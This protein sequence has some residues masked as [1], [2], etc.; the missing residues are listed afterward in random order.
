MEQIRTKLINKSAELCGVNAEDIQDETRLVADLG[1]KSATMVVI[2]AYLEDELDIEIDFM[3][4]N[5]ADTLKEKVAYLY[6]LC[7]N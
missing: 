1:M 4:F 7:N 2:I 3:R 5:K 6:Q